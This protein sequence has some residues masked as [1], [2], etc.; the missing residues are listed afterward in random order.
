MGR[1]LRSEYANPNVGFF[2]FQLGRNMRNL[3]GTILHTLFD[4]AELRLRYVAT[5]DVAK[6]ITESEPI[7]RLTT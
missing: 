1:Y 3:I 4:V 7:K 5:G 2:Q 6:V